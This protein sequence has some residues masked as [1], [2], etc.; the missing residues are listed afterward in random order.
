MATLDIDDLFNKMV[1]A[2]KQS[3]GAEWPAISALATS[4][5]KTLA[6]NL[7]DVEKLV[8]AGTVNQAQANLMIDMQKNSLQ[9]V[10]LSEEGLGLIA[11]QDAINAVIAVVKD[12]VNVAIGFVIL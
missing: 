6:Q 4:S 9:T 3:L 5:L 1:G 11:A 10:L 8:N 12:A 7:I 2:A